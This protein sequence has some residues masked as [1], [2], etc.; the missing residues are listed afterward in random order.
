MKNTTK[1]AVCARQY[2]A[3]SYKSNSNLTVWRATKTCLSAQ[4]R[5]DI[6]A[7]HRHHMARGLE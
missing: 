5:G 6:A 7:V 4:R 2:C 1:I 3:T